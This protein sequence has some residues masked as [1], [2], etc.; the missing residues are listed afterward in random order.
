MKNI[1]SLSLLAGLCLFLAPCFSGCAVF[2]R[3][4]TAE[5]K[6][7]EIQSLA[8]DAASIGTLVTLQSQPQYRPAFQAAHLELERQLDG[9]AIIDL[10]SI[11]A[12]LATLPIREL[13]GERAVVAVTATRIIF[14]RLV[15]GETEEKVHLYS[16]ALA[17][18]IRDGIGA[19]LGK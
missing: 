5:Q 1:K 19:G 14:R 6:A 9:N 2:S 17:T 4:A 15:N 16:R 8:H 10:E 12:V 11:R 3:S 7:A 13:K 18:G